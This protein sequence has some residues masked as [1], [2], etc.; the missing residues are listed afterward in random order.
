MVDGDHSPLID[1]VESTNDDGLGEI[2]ASWIKKEPVSI[3]LVWSPVDNSEIG[4]SWDD[5]MREI[6][7]NLSAEDKEKMLRRNA[8][9]RN[10]HLKLAKSISETTTARKSKASSI[11]I[12]AAHMSD[13][14][15]A[16]SKSSQ[17][18]RTANSTPRIPAA[19]KGKGRDFT[20]APSMD[21][22]DDYVSEEEAADDEA[23]LYQ[24]QADAL[25]AMK[26]QNQLNAEGP[27]LNNVPQEHIPNVGTS[28]LAN[29]LRAPAPEQVNTDHEFAKNLQKM[30]DE[31]YEHIRNLEG[32]RRGHTDRHHVPWDDVNDLQ[33]R[34]EEAGRRNNAPRAKP[35]PMDQIPRSSVLFHEAQGREESKSAKSTKKSKRKLSPP[36][37]DDSSSSSSSDS[38][39]SLP[40]YLKKNR[41]NKKKSKKSKKAKKGKKKSRHGGGGSP[42]SSDDS[43]SDSDSSSSSST[44][45]FDSDWSSLGSPPS[46]ANTDDSVRT[47]RAKKRAKKNFNMKLLRLKLEQSNARPDPPFIYNGEA[48]FSKMERW[49]YEACE[50]TKQSYIRPNMCVPRLSKYLGGRALQ[51]YMRVVAKNAKKWRLNKF[52]EALFNHCFPVDFR[53][54]QRKKFHAFQQRTHSIKEYRTDLEVLADSIGDI[55]T[56]GLVVQFWDG[57]N[58]EM[59]RRW[60]GDGFDPETS[61]LDELE[62]AAVIYEHAIKVEKAQ[63]PD[64]A[65]GSKK[66]KDDEP[67]N[68]KGQKSKKNPRGPRQEGGNKD[69]GP[70]KVQNDAGGGQ[71]SGGNK[72]N[73]KAK[74]GGNKSHKLSK[75]QMN[76]YRAQGKCFTCAETGHLSKDC[77]KNNQ[78]RPKQRVGAAAVSFEE[79]ERLRVLKEA[80]KLGVFAV[81]VENI[82]ITPEHRQAIDDVLVAKMYWDLRREVPFVFDYFG[83]P[84]DD[85]LAEDRFNIIETQEGWLVCDHHTNDHHEV[86][87]SQLLDP[88]FDFIMYLYNEKWAREE[89]LYTEHHPVR[90]AKRE[91]R[92][93]DEIVENLRRDFLNEVPYSFDPTTTEE[94]D[95][96]NDPAPPV[97]NDEDQ[98]Y[99]DT[100][101]DT[102]SWTSGG[103]T[104]SDDGSP[105]PPPP[106]PASGAAVT[107]IEVDADSGSN[108]DYSDMPGL[109]EVSDSESESESGS[110]FDS[111]DSTDSSDSDDD[112]DFDDLPGLQSASDSEDESEFDDS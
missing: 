95:A 64:N 107:P 22:N 83:D 94:H 85:P 40:A 104:S 92:V 44:D 17:P 87:R 89:E 33:R 36:S 71:S 34:R 53:S 73:S 54:I 79:I 74:N 90:V 35:T 27:G 68:G 48:V 5:L 43:S 56:R 42:P 108:F 78:L 4:F 21:Y 24:L 26:L 47:K 60:A 103:F 14:E 111:E 76:E 69:T 86:L 101:S 12:H 58:Y 45:G 88:K 50:W 98:D 32:S 19:A 66:D 28:N 9:M 70:K 110:D 3:E 96:M 91:Q 61:N 38:D 62:A 65:D 82:E 6:S 29:G 63:K 106:P 59:R 51:W 81:K 67:R 18:S 20:T 31:Q 25:L 77:P 100:E 10:A 99:T 84:E 55:T 15:K 105:P 23:R 97:L 72:D 30:F 75:E 102:D 41:K 109:Q 7:N 80:Q 2:P 16:P 49:T 39:D 52:L 37:S 57:A 8:M 1:W 13:H 46:E 93:L 11:S 112:W